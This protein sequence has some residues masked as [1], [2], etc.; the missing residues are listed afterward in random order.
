MKHTLTHPRKGTNDSQT[1]QLHWSPVW[2]TNGFTQITKG[3]RDESKQLCHH[4]H[5]PTQA[6][7][8]RGC[9]P[10]ALRTV[11]RK[12]HRSKTLL[13]TAWLLSLLPKQLTA[14]I[15]QRALEDLQSFRFTRHGTFIYL[16]RLMAA[17]NVPIQRELPPINKEAIKRIHIP[18]PIFEYRSP[19][20][21]ATQPDN[22]CI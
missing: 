1:L 16:L 9:N 17:G 21:C 7:A 15:R 22:L 14:S 5:T 13:S 18:G 4:K 6:A 12:L 11:C 10:R 20:F 19:L 8:H 2:W 3:S